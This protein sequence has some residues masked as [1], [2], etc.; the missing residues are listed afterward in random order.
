MKELLIVTLSGMDKKVS[1]HASPV[2]EEEQDEFAPIRVDSAPTNELARTID[3]AGTAETVISICVD[4]LILAPAMRSTDTV[5]TKDRTLIDIICTC[6]EH[7]NFLLVLDSLLTHVR[8][9]TFSLSAS[10]C[11]RLLSTIEGP[12]R[13]Y[14]YSNSAA[15]HHT[16][17]NLLRATMKLWIP[18]S[19][20]DGLYEKIRAVVAWLSRALQANKLMS[21][22]TRDS[23]GR[24][25]EEYVKQ[26]PTQRIL[27]DDDDIVEDDLIPFLT[28]D[29]DI[30]V[31]FTAARAVSCLFTTASA[32]GKDPTE[33][34]A[35]IREQL[36]VDLSK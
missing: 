32:R 8:L 13:S 21:W 18:L 5:P 20:S 1:K 11:D 35:S 19:E 34:Y 22:H 10:D 33:V 7:A 28:K 24:F 26:G 6:K 3:N 9:N 36:C 30:R 23:I 4:F 25:L 15:L 29:E 2:A 14:Q 27:A 31:R 12:L 17:I 16:V